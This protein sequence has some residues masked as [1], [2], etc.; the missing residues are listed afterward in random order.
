[1]AEVVPSCGLSLRHGLLFGCLP[2]NASPFRTN[3]CDD[4]VRIARTQGMNSAEQFLV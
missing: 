2:R 4:D 1:V 3:N